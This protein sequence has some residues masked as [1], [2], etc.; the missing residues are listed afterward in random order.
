[1]AF[2]KIKCLTL[3]KTVLEIF[4]RSKYF[5]KVDNDYP[6]QLGASQNDSSFLLQ[7]SK[8]TKKNNWSMLSERKRKTCCAYLKMLQ[9]L[10]HWRAIITKVHGVINFHQKEIIQKT[11][12]KN[13]FLRLIKNLVFTKI[14]QDKGKLKKVRT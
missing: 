12:S 8:L 4:K 6:E 2:R 11:R 9:A 14:T 5:L 1:M 3:L 7:K 10:D 13:E